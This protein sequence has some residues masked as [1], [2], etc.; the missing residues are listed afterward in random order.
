MKLGTSIQIPDD[1]A[2]EIKELDDKFTRLKGKACQVARF[3][4]W[5]AIY[6]A[7]PD[8]KTG[9]WQLRHS[10]TKVFVVKM[11]DENGDA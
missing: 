6:D 10:K 8:T 7:A 11:H 1:L 2:L 4:L 9:T 5:T 3:N